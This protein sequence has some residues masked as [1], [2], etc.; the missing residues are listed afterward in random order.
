MEAGIRDDLLFEPSESAGLES[1]GADD[2]DSCFYSRRD[3]TGMELLVDDGAADGGSLSSSCTP[4]ASSWEINV[5]ESAWWFPND[6]P[7]ALHDLRSGRSLLSGEHRRGDEEAQDRLRR[8]LHRIEWALVFASAVYLLFFTV[9]EMFV[10]V[11][12][13]NVG[14]VVR[15]IGLLLNYTISFSCTWTTPLSIPTHLIFFLSFP[16]VTPFT[17][18]MT[19]HHCK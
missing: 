16:V 5:R 1:S 12:D 13:N 9:G 15:I 11:F 14:L 17:I 2:D 7:T 10:D 4:P 3:S 19:E 6:A 18:T 8:R